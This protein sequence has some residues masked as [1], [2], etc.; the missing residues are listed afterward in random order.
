MKR[1]VTY[2]SSV[3]APVIY[4]VNDERDSMCSGRFH[5]I[6]EALQALCAS[7]DSWLGT[8]HERLKPNI[9]RARNCC[10][11]VEAPDTKDF[12]TGLEIILVSESFRNIHGN[13]LQPSG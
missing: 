1:N 5:N 13:L 12:K 3:I 4:E 11:I 2:H 6:V 7:V 9:S 8:F 10:D